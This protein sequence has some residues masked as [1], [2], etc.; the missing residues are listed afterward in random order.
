MA[1]PDLELRRGPGFVLLALP[2]FH[3]SVISSFFTQNKGGQTGPSP[4]SATVSY[5]LVSIYILTNMSKIKGTYQ[6]FYARI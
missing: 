2:A 4:R 1:D 3:P 6:G 5:Y